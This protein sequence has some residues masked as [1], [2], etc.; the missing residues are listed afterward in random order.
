[1]GDITLHAAKV[2]EVFTDPGHTTIHNVEIGATITVGQV[3]CWNATNQMVLADGNVPALDEPW[4]VALQAGRAGQVISVLTKGHCYGFV[5]AGINTG[6]RITLT[7]DPGVME[8]AGSGECCGRV[9]ALPGGTTADYVI[10]FDFD[11]CRA[12]IS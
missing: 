3:L 4:A 12:G 10:H 1:M 5:V 6:V 8:E 11:G 9:V 2:R 7:D